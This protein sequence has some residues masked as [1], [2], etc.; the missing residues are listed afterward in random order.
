MEVAMIVMY[1][2]NSYKEKSNINIPEYQKPMRI[3]D[4]V[5]CL[6][7]VGINFCTFPSYK[8]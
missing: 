3:R 8:N 2:N 6:V 7:G 1:K 5:R 4:F